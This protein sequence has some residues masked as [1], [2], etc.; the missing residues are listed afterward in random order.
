MLLAA[1]RRFLVL[2]VRAGGVTVVGSLAVGLLAGASVSR[3]L[4]VGF[5]CIGSFLLLAGFFVGNRG[6]ARPKGEAGAWLLGPRML[7]W[8]TAEEQAEALNLSAVFIVLG[9][10]L[11]ALGVA[12]D[13][14][15]ELF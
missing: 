14:R 5:Y 3:S 4:S 11:I 7:R 2:L 1:L 12:A 8:A 9:V 6:P 13:S 15:Y 10:A